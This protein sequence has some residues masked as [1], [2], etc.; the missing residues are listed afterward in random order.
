MVRATEIDFWRRLAGFSGGD[1]VRNERVCHIMGVKND[2]EFD[3]MTR[4]LVWYGYVN[5]MTDEILPKR[6]LNCWFFLG[7]DEGDTH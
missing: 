5:R 6:V 4:Q 7:G 3:V 2:I 1:Q